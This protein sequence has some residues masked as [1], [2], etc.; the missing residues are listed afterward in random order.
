MFLRQGSQRAVPGS[1]LHG[2]KHRRQRT[3]VVKRAVRRAY[4]DA[5]RLRQVFQTA[6]FDAP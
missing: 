3:G 1:P 5:M 4:L 6:T 2:L